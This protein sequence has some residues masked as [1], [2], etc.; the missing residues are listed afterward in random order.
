MY[1]LKILNELRWRM[2]YQYDMYVSYPIKISDT[3]T[4]PPFIVC[5]IE[6]L[7]GLH[8]ILLPFLVG[9]FSPRISLNVG[10]FQSIFLGQC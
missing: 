5:H 9:K 4:F 3:V 6:K 7:S 10:N 2:I 1:L 8:L